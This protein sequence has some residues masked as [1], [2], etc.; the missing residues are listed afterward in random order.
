MV[1]ISDINSVVRKEVPVINTGGGGPRD[2]PP[3]FIIGSK[4]SCELCQFLNPIH[5][6][7]ILCEN[8]IS[9]LMKKKE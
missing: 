2:N 6:S 7:S 3:S 5:A 9:F 4:S 1:D 8:C